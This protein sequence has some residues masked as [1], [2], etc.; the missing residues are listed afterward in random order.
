M[1][2][3][4]WLLI[5]GLRHCSVKPPSGEIFAHSAPTPY[6][7]VKKAWSP[8]TTGFAAL[9]VG[10]RA[11]ERQCAEYVA[12]ARIERECIQPCGEDDDRPPV[13][14]HCNGRGVA[15][16]LVGLGPA[17]VAVIGVDRNDAGA[18]AGAEIDQQQIA[19]EQRR[20]S[21]PK[22]RGPE[23]VFL[24]ELPRPEYFAVAQA[25]A[26]QSGARSEQIDLVASDQRNASRAAVRGERRL[27][28][29]GELL[30]PNRFA[31]AGREALG[32]LDVALAVKDDHSVADDRGPGETFSNRSLPQ[33]RRSLRRPRLG[34]LLVDRNAVTVRPQYLRP[35][36][37]TERRRRQARGGE[38]GAQGQSHQSGLP[39]ETPVLRERAWLRRAITEFSATAHR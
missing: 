21:G 38:K 35:I 6:A 5:T 17:R 32:D 8:T 18:V 7:A 2:V 26:V 20:T 14:L 15:G 36:A 22:V 29:G 19:D 24:P 10:P 37:G 28:V 9:T 33:P 23:A 16:P 30:A 12:R 13:D 1:L 39:H 27:V 3:L 4:Y 25:D 11:A 34:K 31:V